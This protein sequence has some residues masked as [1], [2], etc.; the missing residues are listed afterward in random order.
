MVDETF[1]RCALM[2]E[3]PPD[4]VGRIYGAGTVKRYGAGETVIAEGQVNTTLFVVLRGEVEV[5]LP[6]RDDRFTAV[7]L[8]RLGPGSCVGEYSFI[9][10]RPTSAAVVSRGDTEVFALSN[11]ELSRVLAGNLGLERTIYRNLLV[12][13]VE[14]LR[15]DNAVLDMIRP[16]KG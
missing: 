10:Q 3:L 9:D 8:A 6:A 2:N 11:D 5:C 4:D 15:E 16:Q 12:L 14:R 7:R 13:M 1:S